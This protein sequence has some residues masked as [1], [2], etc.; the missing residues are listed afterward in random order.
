M[1][2][3]PSTVLESQKS[4]LNRQLFLNRHKDSRLLSPTP[5]N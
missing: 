4:L 3:L 1:D 5:L 2:H